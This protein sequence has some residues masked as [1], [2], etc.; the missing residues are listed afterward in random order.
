V[1]R[2]DGRTKS[3]LAYPEIDWN[4]DRHPVEVEW[5]DK[6]W[7]VVAPRVPERC[8]VLEIGVGPGYIPS[9]LARL[10]ACRAFG[11]DP[12]QSAM[13]AAKAVAEK[14][15][16]EIHLVR[17]VG[18]SLPFREGAFDV[19]FSLGVI[20]HFPTEESRLMVAEHA[21]VCRDGGL[22]LIGVPNLLNLVHTIIKLCQGKSY[23]Y[24]PEHSYSRPTLTR[25]MRAAGLKPVFHDGY[26]TFWPLRL[27]RSRVGRLLAYAWVRSGLEKYLERLES[28]FTRSW[29]GMLTVVVAR[30]AP[31]GE[32]DR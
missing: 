20:E 16:V 1:T 10:K 30:K 14:A 7:P 31:A 13:S 9:Q 12:L 25:W 11:A 28:P 23:D 8:R 19:V 18:Q 4:W 6:V 15:G 17:G 2:G 27:A 24:Y 26:A 5:Y 32:I 21:R 3:E 29:F 22:V